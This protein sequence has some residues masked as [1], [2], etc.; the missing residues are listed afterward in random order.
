MNRDTMNAA[1]HRFKKGVRKGGCD[2]RE[3]RKTDDVIISVGAGIKSTV[4]DLTGSDTC[5]DDS[6]DD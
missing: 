2:Q 6:K 5:A 3:I 1:Y 4:F